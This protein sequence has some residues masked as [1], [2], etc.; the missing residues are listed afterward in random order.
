MDHA[1][2]GLRRPDSHI[3]SNLVHIMETLAELSGDV[4]ELVNIKKRAMA[5]VAR[6]SNCVDS[7]RYC[8][9]ESKGQS[10][11]IFPGAFLVGGNIS[12]GEKYGSRV[13]GGQG[14]RKSTRLNSSH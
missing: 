14:D 9:E 5:S 6:K 7:Q 1:P 12:L 11:G 2:S 3:A 10:V 13:A 8:D 4:E